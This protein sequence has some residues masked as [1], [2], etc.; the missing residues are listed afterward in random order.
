[1]HITEILRGWTKILSGRTPFLS[2]EITK[3]CPLSCPGCYA[4]GN[5]H[6]NGGVLLTE[7]SDFKNEQ[8]IKGVME[9][10]DRYKPLHV[11]LV[12][13]EPLV[14]FR[15]LNELLPQ[16][17]AQGIHIQLVTSAVRAIPIEWAKI[18]PMTLVVSIDGLQ[19]EHDARRKPATYER[20]LKN[21]EGHKI[22]VHCTITRQIA[23]RPGYLQEFIEFWSARRETE[24]IWMSLFTPQVGETS[25]EI[26]PP[27][28]RQQVL[29]ELLELRE[30]YPKLAMPRGMIEVYADPPADPDHCIFAKTTSNLTAD[31]KTPVTPC[32]FGGNP[33]CTQCGCIASAGLGAIGRHKLPGGI[34]VGAIYNASLRIGNIVASFRGDAA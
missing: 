25:Y 33:D 11:S 7:L 24:K 4:Y 34:P 32:Q 27:D 18:N 1:M 13:G 22:T 17:S 20:I 6:L 31:L 21:I 9:V 30:C 15:E 29:N 19:P 26:L 23:E 5:E 28:L 8:L 3:E 16:I 14:R 12:G 10:I 2:I